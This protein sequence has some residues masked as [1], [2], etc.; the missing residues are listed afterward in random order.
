MCS[1]DGIDSSP[2]SAVTTPRGVVFNNDSHLPAHPDDLAIRIPGARAVGE[3]GEPQCAPPHGLGMRAER[4]KPS[5]WK[6]SG[7]ASEAP[8]QFEVS[9]LCLGEHEQAFSDFLCVTSYTA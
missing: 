8:G 9:S 4:A 5:K 3:A 7:K 1:Q 6:A 2:L